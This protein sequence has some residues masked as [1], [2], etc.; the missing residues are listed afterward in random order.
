MKAKLNSFLLLALSSTAAHAAALTWDA[1]TVTT[2]AQDGSGTWT[3]GSAGWWNGTAN[4]NWTAGDTATF[5][6]GADGTYAITLGGAITTGAGTQ[7]AGALNFA[8]SGYTLSAASP[9]QITTATGTSII[10]VAPGKTA[11]IGSNVTVK[12]GG[13]SNALNILGGGTLRID[14]GGTLSNTFNNGNDI[15]G[16]TTLLINGGTATYGTSL[17]L[18]QL[19]AGDGLSGN[20][21]VDSGSLAINANNLNVGRATGDISVATLN[22]GSITVFANVNFG[23]GGA[24]PTGTF[25]LNGGTLTVKQVRDDGSTSTFN[26][27]GGTLKAAASATVATFFNGIDTAN[28][29]NGGA[30][31]DTNGQAVTIGQ[32]LAHSSIGGD[33]AT[34]GGL[35]KEGSG[36]LTLTGANTSPAPPSSMEVP[37]EFLPPPHR[38]SPRPPS[39]T[40]AASAS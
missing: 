17:V 15:A 7:A 37:S 20:L 5:G 31:I 6:A 34:D 39:T 10:T 27:N 23:V 18:G 26:F 35:T 22:G 4:V 16:G 13:T 29:R 28:V 24:S 2:A 9:Q 11:V 32:I 21:T 25:N 3:T 14:T 30:K 1:D 12:K 40:P 19:N 36:S 33:D 8:N 38:P